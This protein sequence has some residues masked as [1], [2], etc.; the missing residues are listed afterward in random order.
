MNPTF[1]SALTLARALRARTL[2]SRELL[3]HFIARVER[4]NPALNAVVT[5][6]LDRARKAADRADVALARGEVTGPFH[7]VPM[8]IKDTFEVAG[9]RTTAGFPP[10]AEHVPER[11]AEAVLRLR[12]GGVIPFGKT[13][14]PVLAGDWQTYNPIFGAT[15]NPWDTARSPGGS[16]GG[17]AAAVAA[18]LSPLELGSD[19]G[20]SIRVPAHWSG[21]VG[22]KP[23]FGLVPQRGHIPGPPGTLAEPDLNVVGPLA[24]TVEDCE[25]MLDLLAGPTDDRAIAWTLRPPPARH[26][27]LADFR[28]AAWLDDPAYPVDSRVRTLLERAMEALRTAGVMVDARA[29]PRLDFSDAVRTYLEL[30]YPLIMAGY[31]PEQFEAFA[32]MADALARDDESALA[33]T[34]RF[35]TARHREWL[36]ANERRE[37]F[38][39][40]YADLFRRFDVLVTPVNFVPPIAHDHTEPFPARTLGVDGVERSYLDLIAWVGPVTMCWLPATVIPIGATPDGLPVGVQ[41]VGP[42]LEDRTTL[43]F[44]RLAQDVLGGAQPPPGYA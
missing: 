20:G 5:L 29:R 33:R 27:R 18:G 19:I 35:G 10:L 8:T 6:D 37:G 22:H 16:S 32:Q 28:V 12:R 31:P 36:A 39:A 43:A 23:T 17:A 21:I 11:D 9:V 26:E 15:S 40:A 14:V 4:F 38:R 41:I 24:R 1:Q 2:S 25:A 44:A 34:A 42:Y 3:E 30:L 13:N 7:G